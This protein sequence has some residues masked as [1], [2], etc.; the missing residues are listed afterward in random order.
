MSPSRYKF[1][2]IF[3]TVKT[4]ETWE[5]YF[6]CPDC[7]RKA[8]IFFYNESNSDYAYCPKCKETKL[9]QFRE[10]KARFLCETLSRK[11]EVVVAFF[12]ERQKC[13]ILT[14]TKNRSDFE[15]LV[16]NNPFRIAYY[17]DSVSK[18]YSTD[19]VVNYIRPLITRKR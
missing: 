2:V 15:R 10:Y 6:I 19:K 8:L 1:G 3:A 12:N 9:T 4:V 11:K 7:E 18:H 5:E 17:I 16:L 13:D 14:N